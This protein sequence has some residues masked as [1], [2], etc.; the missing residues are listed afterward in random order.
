MSEEPPSRWYTLAEANAA[1]AQLAPRIERL[2]WLRDEA[3]RTKGLLEMLWRRLDADEPV[4][5][6]IAQRQRVLD[7]QAEEF[8]R[9]A[10]EIEH[11]GVIL[12]DLDL[13]LVDFPARVGGVPIFLCWKSDEPEVAF[14]HGPAEG[15][16]GR[17]AVSMIPDSLT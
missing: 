6:A 5:S 12:R 1:R 7:A 3:R 17:K 15:Y 4:L 13:G 16:G 10:D 11:L 9:V 2:R 8:S 14:W